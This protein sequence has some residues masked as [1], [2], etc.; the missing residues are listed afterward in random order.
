MENVEASIER[1]LAWVASGIASII[2]DDV[3]IRLR[4]TCTVPYP[5]ELILPGS[6]DRVDCL[7]IDCTTFSMALLGSGLR[8][9]LYIFV[10]KAFNSFGL[11]LL[12]LLPNGWVAS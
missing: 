1:P 6:N 11:A 2:T 7:C 3:L 5:I 10:R 8:L 4:E 9:L 12:Q